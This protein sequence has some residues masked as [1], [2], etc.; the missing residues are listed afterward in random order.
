MTN[1]EWPDEARHQSYGGLP[2]PTGYPAE[3]E[4]I[5]GPRDGE[6]LICRRPGIGW[7]AEHTHPGGGYY[8]TANGPALW[9]TWRAHT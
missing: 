6:M 2:S 5:G 3:C 9:Y 8:L 4:A 7:V 1:S